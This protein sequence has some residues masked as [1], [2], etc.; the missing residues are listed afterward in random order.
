MSSLQIIYKRFFR[1]KL[2][3]LSWHPTANFAVQQLISNLKEDSQFEESFLTRYLKSCLNC[4]V[5]FNSLFYD[6]HD[7]I[8]GDRIGVVYHLVTACKRF[9]K[10]QEEMCKVSLSSLLKYEESLTMYFRFSSPQFLP[11]KK[12]EFVKRTLSFK[13]DPKK[14][15]SLLYS[16]GLIVR[17]LHDVSDMGCRIIQELFFFNSEYNEFVLKR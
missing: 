7:P 14:V 6:I 13:T 17:Q 12:N 15:E 11:T 5:R 8:E 9:N 3:H 2:V 1:K 16:R 10:R 4:L